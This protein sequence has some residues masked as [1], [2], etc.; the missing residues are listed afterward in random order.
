MDHLDVFKTM[1]LRR[2]VMLA[3]FGLGSAMLA[4]VW[5][6]WFFLGAGGH[7]TGAVVVV[8]LVG[9]FWLAVDRLLAA[10]AFDK[11]SLPSRPEYTNFDIY[12]H[13]KHLEELG[14][15]DLKSLTFVVFDTETTGLRPS[16]GDEIISIAGVRIVGGEIKTGEA[17][18]R[19]V[20]P[21]RDIPRASIRFHGITEDMVRGEAPIKDVLPEFRDFIGDVVLVAHNAAFDMKF[22]KLKERETGIVFD[23]LVLD[24][25]LLSVFLEPESA[26]HGLDA[27]AERL[28]V[29]VEGRH[30]ALG[31]SLATAAVFLRMLSMLETRGVRTLGQA[32][33]V[34]S[35]ISHVRERQ[36]QF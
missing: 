31:D 7:G 4:V 10:R 2:L 35:R 32:I 28:G 33:Q 13:P 12:D 1:P 17:F 30:T 20:N 21:G 27:I 29:T 3:F 26:N 16:H 6:A 22:L 11:N 18:S 36:K 34:S 8:I 23:H 24:S 9:G 14:G 25:L 15:R 19:L 5:G